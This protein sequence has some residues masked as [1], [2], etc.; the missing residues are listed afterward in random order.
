MQM[1]F[2]P[3]RRARPPKGRDRLGAG[4]GVGSEDRDHAFLG[5]YRRVVAQA[6]DVALPP[7]GEGGDAGLFGLVDGH[8]R[9]L[10]GYHE[11]EAPMSVNN[12]GGWRFAQ[13]LKRRAG[14]DVP[15]VNALAVFG[16]VNAAVGVVAH[17]VRFDL[18][19]GDDFSLVGRRVPWPGRW[20]TQPCAGI[21]E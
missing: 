15:A 5:A 21:R 2:V 18:V 6:S 17:Q 9:G 4:A 10:L 12:G 8:A 14:N 3:N 11:A 19:G 7:D 13:H 20:R 1:G 16:Y